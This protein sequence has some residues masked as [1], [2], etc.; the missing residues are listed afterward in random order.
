VQTGDFFEVE[1]HLAH[2]RADGHCDQSE[3]DFLNGDVV[4]LSERQA[5]NLEG[6]VRRLV[7]QLRTGLDSLF[8]G[9]LMCHEQRFAM[10][11]RPEL[12]G[13]LCEADRLTQ[14]YE[15]RYR[16]YD[17]IAEYAKCKFDTH[18][19]E[20]NVDGRGGVRLRLTGQTTLP[21]QVY[22][23]RDEGEGCAHRYQEVPAF[24]GSTEV[25]W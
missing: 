4:G 10:L 25:S 16:G 5:H 18:I 3:I 19:A 24:A 21:L 17:H 20:A 22:V 6:A 9:A 7:K 23:F 14:G 1:A 8:F 15:K 2:W 11:T 12:E 13:V